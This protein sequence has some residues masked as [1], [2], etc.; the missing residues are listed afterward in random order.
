[1][2]SRSK[3]DSVGL[4]EVEAGQWARIAPHLRLKTRRGR[5]RRDARRTFNGIL[6]V[7]SSGARWED[8]PVRYGSR[9]T[10]HRRFQEWQRSGIWS[11]LWLTFL[12]TLDDRRKR[13]WA[14]ALLAGTFVPA[15]KDHRAAGVPRG[16]DGKHGLGSRASSDTVSRSPG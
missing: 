15:K 3:I 9:S 12:R 16:D 10:C 4:A 8:L 1:M 14:K 7:L 5:P 6:W 2:K 13:R 11:R